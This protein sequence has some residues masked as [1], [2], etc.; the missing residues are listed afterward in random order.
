MLEE[1]VHRLATLLSHTLYYTGLVGVSLVWTKISCMLPP[2][3][4][5]KDNDISNSEAES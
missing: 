5:D 1:S 4:R 3:Q 2:V